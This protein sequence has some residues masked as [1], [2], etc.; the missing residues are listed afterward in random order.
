MSAAHAQDI[1][2]HA[3]PLQVL[4]AAEDIRT[5]LQELNSTVLETTER[6]CPD[7]ILEPDFLAE[8]KGLI[9]RMGVVK[10]DSTAV[11]EKCVLEQTSLS[12]GPNCTWAVSFELKIRNFS[13]ELIRKVGAGIKPKI[14][15]KLYDV[16]SPSRDTENA[17]SIPFVNKY[18]DGVWYVSAITPSLS[19]LVVE[20]TIDGEHIA[21]SPLM[22]TRGPEITLWGEKTGTILG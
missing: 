14:S 10:D 11:P 7:M 19:G 20:S 16:S 12:I 4:I 5:H 6:T 2:H 22:A 8:V 21:S 13:G 3:T 17:V 15:V 18:A 9:P 1:L